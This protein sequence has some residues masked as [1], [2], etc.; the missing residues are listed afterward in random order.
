MPDVYLSAVTGLY[1][2]TVQRLL[3]D[4]S[5]DPVVK[6]VIL[7]FA[8]VP[9]EERVRV[10]SGLKKKKTAPGAGTSKSGKTS[11]NG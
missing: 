9:R 1:G 11:R 3:C 5:A 6:A 4:P 7:A 8:C 2:K 10:L